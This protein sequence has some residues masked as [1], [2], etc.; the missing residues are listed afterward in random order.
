MGFLCYYT[1]KSEIL[2]RNFC[3]QTEGKQG[4]M[5]DC[6]GHFKVR[7]QSSKHLFSPHSLVKSP[8]NDPDLTTR[9]R[10]TKLSNMLE[11][12]NMI[13]HHLANLATRFICNPRVLYNKQQHLHLLYSLNFSQFLF[14][15]K[16]IKGVPLWHSGL[17][18]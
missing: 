9:E 4:S 5:E 6:S 3:T 15:Q 8:I 10:E 1:I 11:S 2:W 12:R 18:I 16:C 13:G 14:F 17:S 7:L